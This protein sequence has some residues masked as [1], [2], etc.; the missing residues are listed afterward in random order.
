LAEVRRFWLQHWASDLCP[1][2][3]LSALSLLLMQSL[4]LKSI[5]L[6]NTSTAWPCQCFSL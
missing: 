1:E 2:V 4:A 3:C 5:T 6:L